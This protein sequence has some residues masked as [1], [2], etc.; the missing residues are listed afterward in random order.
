MRMHACVH[1]HEC[2]CIVC[3]RVH[4]PMCVQLYGAWPAAHPPTSQRSPSHPGRVSGLQLCASLSFQGELPGG[5]LLPL[6]PSY[7][8]GDK[9]V[10]GA[11]GRGGETFLWDNYRISG[12]SWDFTGRDTEIS[13]C[14]CGTA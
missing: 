3:V 4:V 6:P 12:T 1:V 14:S 13:T 5:F 2:T 10:L 11:Q 8:P 7:H 9:A